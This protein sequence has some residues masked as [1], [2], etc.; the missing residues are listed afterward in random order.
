MYLWRI[1]ASM[2]ARLGKKVS[3]TDSGQRNELCA[4]VPQFFAPP[5]FR[6]D[7][8]PLYECNPK[9]IQPSIYVHAIK[10]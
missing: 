10:G 1:S 2:H 9:A 5:I 3:D 6:T 7:S 8:S 4:Y